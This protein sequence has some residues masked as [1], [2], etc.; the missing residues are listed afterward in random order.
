[1][2]L[3]AKS[4]VELTISCR[5]LIAMPDSGMSQNWWK[6]KKGFVLANI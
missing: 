3:Y 1:M 5:I 6:K 4:N 2:T